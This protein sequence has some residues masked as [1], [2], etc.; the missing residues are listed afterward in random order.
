[1]FPIAHLGPRIPSAGET[2]DRGFRCHRSARDSQGQASRGP[3][4]ASTPAWFC[5]R[6][7]LAN[8]GPNR[9]GCTFGSTLATRVNR[10]LPRVPSS[11]YPSLNLRT[12]LR[13]DL[14]R[15]SRRARWPYP[16]S[17]PPVRRP[18]RSPLSRGSSGAS[19]SIRLR[20]PRTPAHVVGRIEHKGADSLDGASIVAVAPR[21][22]VDTCLLSSGHTCRGLCITR[23]VQAVAGL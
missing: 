12:G 1:M 2:L 21:S 22:L 10:V 23:R 3:L 18:S 8:S 5:I 16:S 19:R 9:R 20:Q 13:S 15:P 11:R 4:R 14:N 7:I 6:P 17:V